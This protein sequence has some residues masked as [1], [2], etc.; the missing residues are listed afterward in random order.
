MNSVSNVWLWNVNKQEFTI[1]TSSNIYTFSQML[2]LHSLAI[3]GFSC[4]I[5]EVVDNST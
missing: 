2:P 4:E 3:Y 1:H 5:I